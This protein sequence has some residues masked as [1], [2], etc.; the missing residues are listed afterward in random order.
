MGSVYKPGQGV[1]N[2]RAGNRMTG[3]TMVK[4]AVW[5][6]EQVKWRS[7]P[8]FAPSS[9]VVIIDADTV[10]FVLVAPVLECFGTEHLVR[11]LGT[12]LVGS[13]IERR[14][15]WTSGVQGTWDGIGML[16]LC[17]RPYVCVRICMY[18]CSVFDQIFPNP[19]IEFDVSPWQYV[20][21]ERPECLIRRSELHVYHL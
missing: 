12:H 20:V 7:Y 10:P 17:M 1:D 19:T 15:R 4:K 5:T 21:V 6:T 3:K 13:R 18:V 8:I 14:T 9:R 2:E 11:I 16:C